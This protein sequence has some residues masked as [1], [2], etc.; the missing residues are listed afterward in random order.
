[1]AERQPSSIVRT[2]TGLEGATYLFLEVVEIDHTKL[3][4]MLVDDASTDFRLAGPGSL[5]RLMSTAEW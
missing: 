5:W 2:R 3:D 1:M 4:L